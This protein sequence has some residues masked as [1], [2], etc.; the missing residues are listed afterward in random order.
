M[1]YT[2]DIRWLP[3]SRKQSNRTF[4]VRKKILI[5]QRHPASERFKV[6]HV[7][8]KLLDG[9]RLS[10]ELTRVDDKPFLDIK[11]ALRP[12]VTLGK[13]SL[14]IFVDIKTYLDLKE[15][16]KNTL[17]SYSRKFDTGILFFTTNY[18]GYARDF[19]LNVRKPEKEKN[20]LFVKINSSS[21][22][23]K[24][25]K[26]GGQAERPRVP[27]GIGTRWMYL[28]YDP[29]RVPYETVAHVL[30]G[31]P[32]AKKR[33]KRRNPMDPEF[34]RVTVLLDSG[35]KDGVKRVF[36]AGGFPFFVHTMLFLDSLDFLTSKS[37]TFSLNRYL[38]VDMDDV[39]IG[40]TGLRLRREDV[41]VRN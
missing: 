39:F 20:P 24:V 7:L 23:L 25:T 38:Q 3:N 19:E 40:S 34:D 30:P 14:I 37:L 16:T 17:N 4:K 29:A 10:Y 12:E 6:S 32:L 22:I 27:K 8:C 1:Y 18:V 9:Y 2:R 11:D 35:R 36:F 5:V 21:V 15:K 33:R 13:Y 26:D 28:S 31:L 41:M